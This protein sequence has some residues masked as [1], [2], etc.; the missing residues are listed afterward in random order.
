MTL[1]L[2]YSSTPNCWLQ[3]ICI[4]FFYIHISNMNPMRE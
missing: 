3:A 4:K 1:F 2:N